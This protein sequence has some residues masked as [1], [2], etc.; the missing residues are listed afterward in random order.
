MDQTHPPAEVDVDERLAASL[1]EAMLP[2]FAEYRPVLVDEGWDNVTYRLGPELALRLPRREVAVELLLNEQRWL[3]EIAGWIDLEVPVPV[4]R[5]EPS[6]L[7]PWPWSVV[8][9]IEGGTVESSS[10][11]AE[12][13]SRLAAELGALHRPASSDTPTN[14]FRGVPLGERAEVVE[15]RLQRL[16]E[17]RLTHLWAAALE[18]EPPG[19]SV[20]LHGDLHP[21][22]VIVR[23]GRLTGLIDWGDLCGGDVATDL[24]CA[25][26]LFESAARQAFLDAYPHDRGDRA[27]AVGWAVNYGTGLIESGEPRH[28]PIGRDILRRLMEP[29]AR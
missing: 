21:R 7:F 25:W 19:R 9:W 6:D 16:G 12:D 13:A 15:P 17:P 8:R 1:V 4:A 10:L 24:A 14:P 22:N 27:R 2:E 18:A 26:T 28:V 20:W 29:A 11:D 23:N 5:G 3:P